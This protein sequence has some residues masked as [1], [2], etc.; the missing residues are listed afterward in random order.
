MCCGQKRAA[1]QSALTQGKIP[2]P[3]KSASAKQPIQRTP[4]HRPSTNGPS[5]GSTHP[6][7]GHPRPTAQR[8][9]TP[10]TEQDAQP[11]GTRVSV[12]Y[13][14]TAPMRVLGQVTGRHY[15]FS[16]S[17]PAQAVDPL[18]LPSILAT[19]YFSRT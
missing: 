5:I 4:T 2:I 1:L 18:D 6:G 12:R 3:A 16:G 14:R 15:D 8:P 17:R 11:P 10:Q 9:V 13:V 7:P 19:G